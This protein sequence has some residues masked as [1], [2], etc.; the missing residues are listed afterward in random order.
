M[1]WRAIQA[2]TRKDITVILRSKMILLPLILLPLILQVIMPAAFGFGAT[3]LT[4][5]SGEMNDLGQLLKAMPPSVQ[6]EFGQM[7]ERQLFLVLSLVYMFAPMYLIMPLMA[8]SV[9]AADSFVGERERKTLESLL[10][11]PLTNMEMLTGKLLA[12]MLPAIAISWISF[13]L[14]GIIANAVGWPLMG[15]IFFPNWTWIVLVLWVAPATSGLGLSATMIIS[16]KVQT[17][18]EAYQMSGVVVLPI[19]GLMIGQVS[20]VI[21]L[22]P[23]FALGL[24]G[25]IWIVDAILLTYGVRSFRR[26][27]LLARL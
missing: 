4:V 14:Y 26:E 25:A 20:G 10:H 19:I 27:E 16:S 8:S 23:A 7:S 15:R 13:V 24:G 21:Y 18:Q 22:S 6:A 5:D 3:Y 1:N 2:I 9:I 17:F 11:S 12:A